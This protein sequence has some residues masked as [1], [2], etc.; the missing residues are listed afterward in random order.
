MAFLE[1]S[2]GKV[3]VSEPNRMTWS[4]RKKEEG[5]RKK[6]LSQCDENKL[7]NFKSVSDGGF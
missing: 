4:R 5:K 2:H 7:V 1:L 3:T 6:Y